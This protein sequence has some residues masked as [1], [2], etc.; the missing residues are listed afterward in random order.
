M[1]VMTARQAKAARGRSSA[2]EPKRS[3][4]VEAERSGGWHVCHAKE[5]V[6]W[7]SSLQR[8]APFVPGK[9]P[10]TVLAC[11]EATPVGCVPTDVCVRA[12]QLR[13]FCE[14]VC[15]SN[16]LLGVRRLLAALAGLAGGCGVCMM[17]RGVWRGT[18]AAAQRCPAAPGCCGLVR[19]DERSSDTARTCEPPAQSGCRVQRR[20]PHN[21]H[22]TR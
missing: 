17:L 14:S 3:E 2:S 7:Q 15:G 8:S 13:V 11:G 12:R 6:T 10:S 9:R 4:P 18:R 22:E 19:G 20:C 21:R 5:G 1:D 16:E